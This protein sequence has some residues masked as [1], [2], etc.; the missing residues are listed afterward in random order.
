MLCF[1]SFGLAQ[2]AVDPSSD[3]LYKSMR[4][5]ETMWRLEEEK[6][7][8][9]DWGWIPNSKNFDEMFRIQGVLEKRAQL[10]EAKASFYAGILAL[11]TANMYAKTYSKQSSLYEE[12]YDV[13]LRHFKQ[14]G[15]AGFPSGYWNAAVMYED[16]TGVMRSSTAAIELYFKAGLGYLGTNE[17]EKALSSL[18]AI[19]R[20]DKNHELAKQLESQ[21]KKAAVK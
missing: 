2:P 14:A 21:L 3:Q 11:E 20:I 1:L 15:N 18:E 10:G 5:Y 17:R 8:K 12:N 9:G 13:A 16:G 7:P 4:F 6:K 19:Y